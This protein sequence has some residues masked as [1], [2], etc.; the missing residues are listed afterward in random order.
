[1]N[2]LCWSSLY[3]KTRRWESLIASVVYDEAHL[4]E[5][6]EHIHSQTNT[7]SLVETFI[8]GRELYVGLIGNRRIEVLPIWEMYFK[9]PAPNS[10][11]I[12]TS[13]VKWD[14]EYQRKIG[15]T[16]AQATGISSGVE[17]QIALLCK[18]GL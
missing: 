9:H 18:T 11:L 4:A 5:R 13:R 7:D 14:P 2:S 8:E 16:T 17:A 15:I 10:P 1:M 12:A 6:V 3:Q